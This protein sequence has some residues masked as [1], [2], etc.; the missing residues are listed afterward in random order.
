M[1]TKSKSEIAARIN[2]V[3]VRAVKDMLRGK[4]TYTRIELE[5]A[6]FFGVIGSLGKVEYSTDL[7]NNWNT[8]TVIRVEAADEIALDKDNL[9]FKPRYG[10]VIVVWDSA[11]DLNVLYQYTNLKLRV[12]FY[13]RAMQAGTESEYIETTISTF[14]QQPTATVQM[15]RPYRVEPYLVFKFKSLLSIKAVKFHFRIDIAAKDDTTFT[16][17]LYTYM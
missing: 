4:D 14:S 11:T 7:G 6:N 13:D 16:T 5:A 9:Y 8:A 17:P 2:K 10:R 15:L 3:T 1:I 12:T